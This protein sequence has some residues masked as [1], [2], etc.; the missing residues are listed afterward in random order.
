VFDRDPPVDKTV[1]GN[2]FING[3]TVGRLIMLG[4]SDKL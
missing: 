3:F 2:G 1:T 4:I